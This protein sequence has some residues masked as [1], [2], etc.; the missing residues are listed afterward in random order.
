MDIHILAPK[1]G[2]DYPVNWNQFLDWFATEEAC[3]GYL[4]RLRW[5]QGFV[6]PRCG[7]GAEPYRSS[8]ARLMC[9]SCSTQSTV[10]AGTIFEKTRTPLRVWLA[11]AWYVTNQKHGVSALGLQRVLGLGSYQ[12]AWAMLHRL[13]RAMVRPERER[14]SGIVEVD[15]TYL[16]LSDREQPV[17]RGRGKGRKSQTHQTP[18]VIA[19]ELH[20]P[21]GF[22]RLRLERILNDSTEQVTPFVLANIEPGSQVRTDG[23]A[24]YRDLA[25]LGYVHQRTVHLGSDVPAHVSM[26]GV[27]RV[28]A[29]IKRWVLGTHQGAVQPAHL[30]AY[31]DEFVFRFNR[32][33]SRSRGLLFY[34]LLEQAVVTDPLTYRGVVDNFP[35]SAE[36]A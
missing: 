27:H 21:K 20:E 28:A 33:A 26:V 36:V 34:R 35:K 18:V 7:V 23:S 2:E 25:D 10:T 30:D 6:C 3:L 24:V 15:E 29:L 14:L 8:R 5:P 19:V 13:R 1:A 22:G 17:A 12:T 4:E 9:R 16:A 11:A 31:L 32:R